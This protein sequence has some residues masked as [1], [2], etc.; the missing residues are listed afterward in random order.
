MHLIALSLGLHLGGNALAAATLDDLLTA[1]KLGDAAAVTQWVQKGMDVNA[2][3]AHGNTLL[4]L[5]AREDQPAVVEALIRQGARLDARNPA[6]DTAL[7]L[8]SLKVDLLLA[9]G[10]SFE[11]AG[12][13]PLLYAAFEGQVAVVE[14]LLAKGADPNRLAPNQSTPLM[15]AARNGHEAV[16][17]RLLK[18]GA[19]IDWQNDQK[20][21]AES[22][23]LKNRNTDIAE[24]I[25]AERVARSKQLK[26]EIE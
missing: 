22:W 8:A 12:W 25:Q 4:I 17:V 26:I 20:E 13:N 2:T 16:V 11:H 15:Y 18:A 23:A 7:M 24:L 3:D 1:T 14:R 10:A 19:N 21:T 9:A 5:A 6:G